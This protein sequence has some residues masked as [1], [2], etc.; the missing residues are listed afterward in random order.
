MFRT[1]PRSPVISVYKVP[2]PLKKKLKLVSCIIRFWWKDSNAFLKLHKNK[3]MCSS[4]VCL[5]L[6]QQPPVC[7]GL[8]IHK[9]LRSHTT[10]HSR[11]ETSGRANG[12]SWRPLPDNTHDTHDRQ[13]SMPL[14]GFEPAFSAVE[15]PQTFALDCVATGI[16]EVTIIPSS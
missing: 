8:L 6:A 7:Q 16:G 11:Y 3:V 15:R 13:T 9:V 2:H 12:P 1:E 14:V 10:H 5:L 4:H